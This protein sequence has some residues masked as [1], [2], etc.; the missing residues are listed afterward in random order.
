MNT[1]RTA[2]VAAIVGVHPNTVRLYEQLDLIPKTERRP[3]GYRIYTDFHIQQFKLAR[4]AFQVEVLQ[5]GLRKKI[6]LLYTSRCV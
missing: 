3:N 6:C 5:N 1:Y 4:L 2:Q